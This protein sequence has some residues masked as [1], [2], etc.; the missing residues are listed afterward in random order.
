[1][2]VNPL[3]NGPVA[4]V[5]GPQGQGKAPGTQDDPAPSGNNIIHPGP[6]ANGNA[7]GVIRLL[8]EGHFQG[9]SG[10]RLQINFHEQ[11]AG[12]AQQSVA[13]T[14]D[15]GA[16]AIL[17]AVDAVVADFTANNDLSESI[18]EGITSAQQAFNDAA[19]ALFEE[20]QSGTI[21]SGELFASLQAAFE[22]FLASI[23]AV[24][25]VGDK[26]ST[27]DDTVVT[28]TTDEVS[29][30]AVIPTGGDIIP[31]DPVTEDTGEP[32]PPLEPDYAAFLQALGD[33]FSGALQD[34]ELA[35]AS[36]ESTV[37]EIS[38]PNGNGVAFAKFLDILNAL[39]GGTEPVD[40]TTLGPEIDTA[41]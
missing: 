10:V 23:E 32:A 4:G 9:V 24:V 2:H 5:R 11:L 8:Q 19:T 38:E 14:A 21:G 37:P 29:I 6:G 40:T 33:A 1:M 39:N 30:E 16:E 35:L 27:E 28:V 41:A 13:S 36:A 17:A 25:P 15:T 31:L 3:G 34:L 20:F 18:L 12:I 22:D 7:R 26:S